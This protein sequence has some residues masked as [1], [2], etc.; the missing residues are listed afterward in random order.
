[1]TRALNGDKNVVHRAT[2][3]AKT[4]KIIG[5]RLVRDRMA[6]LKRREAMDLEG[7][8]QKLA[9]LLASEEAALQ[10]EYQDG[11]ETPEQIREKMFER[12]TDLKQKRE[13]ER[14]AEVNRRLEKHFKATTDEL[15]QEDGKFYTHG[16]QLER[17]KQL[18]D[19]MRKMEQT[20]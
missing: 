16:T 14:Q 11:L 2:W 7:R 4:E 5:G 17:E 20:R 10:Q 3:E 18:I 15:R 6:D 12:M 9:A 8:K 1:M 19:K 13:A